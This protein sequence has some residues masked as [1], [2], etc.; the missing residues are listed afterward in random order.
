MNKKTQL[1][2]MFL[3]IPLAISIYFWFSEALLRGGYDLAIDGFVV[4]RALMI[5]YTLHLLGKLGEFIIKN[6]KD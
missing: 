5:I 1:A 3:L 6:K 4:A 2:L